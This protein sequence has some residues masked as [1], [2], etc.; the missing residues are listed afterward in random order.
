MQAS[1]FTDL[2]PSDQ[3]EPDVKSCPSAKGRSR[4]PQGSAANKLISGEGLT[5]TRLWGVKAE[6]II[7]E[8]FAEEVMV[9]ETGEAGVR[10]GEIFEAE[11]IEGEAGAEVISVGEAWTGGE[12]EGA[13]EAM[14]DE[15][16]AGE[17]GIAADAE[18]A[19]REVHE[20]RWNGRASGE[21]EA[22][23]PIPMADSGRSVS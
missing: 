11:C 15:S 18:S 20:G 2:S 6:G 3:E 16:G 22:F 17:V 23:L 9:G 14:I 10:T 7:G 12:K 8:A 1:G 4:L 19:P 13:G 5:V 21:A